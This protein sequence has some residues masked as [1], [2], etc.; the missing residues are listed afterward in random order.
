MSTEAF[1]DPITGAV[2]Y[3]LDFDSRE[4]LTEPIPADLPPQLRALCE[5]W[6]SENPSCRFAMLLTLG[7]SQYS[8]RY[9]PDLYAL[10]SAINSTNQLNQLV[11]GVCATV[12]PW[13]LEI[14]PESKGRLPAL[15]S[16]CDPGAPA[17]STH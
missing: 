3:E 7:S 17:P 15:L 10:A 16:P 8:L 6:R 14:L 1:A 12:V 4:W 5:L 2:V 9:F 11:M 13:R